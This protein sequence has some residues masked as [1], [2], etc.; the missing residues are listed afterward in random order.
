[1]SNMVK[2]VVQ[3]GVRQH[4]SAWLAGD[5][6]SGTIRICTEP[7]CEDNFRA[8]RLLAQRGVDPTRYGLPSPPAEDE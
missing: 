8:A 3:D 5:D 7:R 4:V 6:F 2:H 1:M